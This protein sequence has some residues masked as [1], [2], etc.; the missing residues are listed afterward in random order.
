MKTA[1]VMVLMLCCI[2]SY[3]QSVQN[4]DSAS[5]DEKA[6]YLNENLDKFLAQRIVYP[7]EAFTANIEGDVIFSFNIGRDGKLNNL[8]VVSS[9]HASL[10]SSSMA[11]LND[12]EKEW[13]PARINGSPADKNYLFVF[14]FRV[15]KNTQPVNYSAIAE[16]A[17][18]KKKYEQ[19]LKYYNEAIK[20]NR[21]IPDFYESRSRVKEMLGDT[22]GARND[23]QTSKE[24]NDQIMSVIDIAAIGVSR[25]VS[26]GSGVTKVVY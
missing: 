13:N 7:K 14:R 11:A 3:S 8:A 22:E 1:L 12:L 10:T 2:A 5:A 4:S 25:T 24:F 6:K 9:P 26:K 18:K 23:K 21:F 15:Y 17:F 19:A 20:D 16:R